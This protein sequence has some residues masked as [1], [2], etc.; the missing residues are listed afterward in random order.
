MEK[1]P[2]AGFATR[3]I[4]GAEGTVADPAYGSVV[5]PIHMSTAFLFEDAAQGARRIA[6]QEE[7][8]VYTRMGNPTVE[9]LERR[10]ASLEGG[11]ESAAFAS[12][13]GAIASLL[14]HV[15]QPGE[16]ILSVREVYGGTHALFEVHLPRMGYG[17]GYFDPAGKDLEAELEARRTPQ[18]RVLYLESPSNPSLV[19]CD[20]ETCVRWAR[21]H[22]L[23]TVVDNTF[24]TSYVQ[25]PLGHGVDWVVYSATKYL[26]GHGD[27]VGG[28][29]VG[30][31]ADIR[32]LRPE[33]QGHFGNILSPFNAWLILRGL[34]TLALRMERHSETALAVARFLESHP[35]VERVLYPGLPSHPQHALAS[36]QM[37]RPGGMVSFV[38]SSREAGVRLMDRLKLCYRAVSLGH[39]G[40][41]VEHPASMTHATYSGEECRDAGLDTALVRLSAGLEAP[42][43]LLADLSQGL[44][45]L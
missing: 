35:K 7:G 3:A 9:A 10:V 14:L 26:N 33:M 40:T 39:V 4:H 18:T 27:A 28:V 44:A 43:D 45:H 2:E 38:M 12:G 5:P 41:L 15:L 36:R 13:M 17:V 25:R 29:V 21:R 11:E 37:R 23:V 22:G 20:L 42:E 6:G 34:Q 19:L 16:H 1:H 32:S 31:A 30:R 8:Y 24:C